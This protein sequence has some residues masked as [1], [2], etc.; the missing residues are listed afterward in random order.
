MKQDLEEQ[1]AIT[2]L[3][4]HNLWAGSWDLLS[5]PNI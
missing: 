5:L 3:D 4:K 2:V 1:M